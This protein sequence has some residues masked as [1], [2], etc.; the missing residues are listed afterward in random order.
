MYKLKVTAETAAAFVKRNPAI[1]Q[2]QVNFNSVL[3][4]SGQCFADSAGEGIRVSEEQLLGNFARRS[5]LV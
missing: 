5:K 4:R 1:M 3:T 2:R